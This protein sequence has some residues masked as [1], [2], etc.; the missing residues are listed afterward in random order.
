ME[1]LTALCYDCNQHKGNLLYLPKS[2]YMALIGT[3]RLNQ[4]ETMVRKWFQNNMQ[5]RHDIQQYPLIAPNCDVLMPLPNQHAHTKPKYCKQFL[6]QWSLVGLE[7]IDE[8]EAITGVK[9]NVIRTLLYRAKDTTT[10][11]EETK[12]YY[13]L[14]VTFYALRKPSNQKILALMAVRYDKNKQDLVL[15][16]V[17]AD[18]TKKAHSYILVDFILLL[19]N[20]IMEIAQYNIQDILILSTYEDSFDAITKQGISRYLCHKYHTTTLFDS[21][22]NKNLYAITLYRKKYT[23]PTTIHKYIELPKWLHIIA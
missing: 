7:T 15:Y 1:N 19:F 20:S 6:L 2:F 21:Y 23:P 5:E 11:W 18:T 13:G 10:D 4:M 22:E 14:P 3:P 17:W 12:H 9:L 16:L 8:I